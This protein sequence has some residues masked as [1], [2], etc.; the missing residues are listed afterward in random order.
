MAR[1]LIAQHQHT[2][3]VSVPDSG[4]R[5]DGDIDCLVQVLSNLLTNAARYTPPGGQ[6]AL[7]ASG[8][9][10]RV[11]VACEDDWAGGAA[12]AGS[13]AVRAVCAGASR[14]GPP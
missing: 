9:A 14:A 12:G 6:I 4:L 13:Q 8:S 5:V 10:D 1:P 7:V 3:Q 2:L 11:V